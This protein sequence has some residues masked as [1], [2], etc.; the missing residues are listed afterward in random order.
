[1][2]TFFFPSGKSESILITDLYNGGSIVF[3]QEKKSK[4]NNTAHLLPLLRSKKQRIMV[5]MQVE[6]FK[7]DMRKKFH[8][9]DDY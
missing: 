4:S 9:R 8:H 3:Q 6:R 1:M 5:N 2:N 7:S